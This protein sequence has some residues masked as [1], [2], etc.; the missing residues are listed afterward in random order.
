MEPAVLTNPVG[1]RVYAYESHILCVHI[2]EYTLTIKHQL[3]ALRA[4]IGISLN[5]NAER[6]SQLLHPGALEEVDLLECQIVVGFSRLAGSLWLESRAP[7]RIA[8]RAVI[9]HVYAVKKSR[10]IADLD[11]LLSED[12]CKLLSRDSSVLVDVEQPERLFK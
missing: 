6:L 1:K 10:N 7:L 11:A 3:I 2:A 8:D 5:D 4:Y 12:L 9:R